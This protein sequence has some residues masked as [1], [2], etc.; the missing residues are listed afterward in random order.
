M[1]T[2]IKNDSGG[3][4]INLPQQ[5]PD[6]NGYY[7]R[8]LDN[9]TAT[10]EA[11]AEARR[12]LGLSEAPNVPTQ[13]PQQAQ[14]TQPDQPI[15]NSTDPIT[16]FNLSILDMLHKAQGA[17]G[18]EDS[19]A[20]QRALQ[21][22]A[23]GRQSEITPEELRNLSPA[24]QEAIRSGKI[25]A[26]N[27]EIDAVAAKIK[28][29]DSRLSNFEN[30]LSTIKDI[31]GDLLK[32]IAPSPE[33]TGGYINM[34]RAGADISSIP[35]EIRNKIV[36][37]LSPDDWSAW[38][39]A[40]ESAKVSSKPKMLTAGAI[41]TLSEG[42]QIPLVTKGLS[43]LITSK[44]RLFGPIKGFFEKNNPYDQEAQVAQAS[45]NRAAQVIGK[46]MEG[47]VLRKEDEAKYAN[48]LPKLTDT[49]EVAK[50]KLEDVVQLLKDKSNQYITDYDLGGYD[51]SGF[52]EIASQL[53]GNNT[54]DLRSQVLNMGYDYDK[55]RQQYSD[56]E[57]KNSLGIR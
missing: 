31:G 21:R 4:N 39:Q 8:V 9:P 38:Q 17:S 1:A 14:P 12:N 10:P 55:M 15:V 45:L 22:A 25:E 57:I 6:W 36:S 27:P 49:P 42:R 7:K 5:N 3:F 43:D 13:A 37:K 33:I 51:V 18:N 46:F 44:S 40:K 26:L 52:Q 23:I 48:I 11:K 56:E 53:E 2:L 50:K 32:N 54:T 34:I 29:Q 30:M 41:S 20:Q 19:F 47:G 16:R 35:V 24:Q 28:A